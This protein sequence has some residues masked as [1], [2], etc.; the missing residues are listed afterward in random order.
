MMVGFVSFLMPFMIMNKT[1][2]SLLLS[3]FIFGASFGVTSSEALRTRLK[4]PDEKI[5]T[6]VVNKADPAVVSVVVSKDLPILEEYYEDVEAFGGFRIVQKKSRQVGSSLQNIGGGTAFFINK[7]GLLIT[8]EHVVN[9]VSAAYTVVMNDGVVYDA[10]VL[11]RDKNLDLALLKVNGSGFPIIRLSS[12]DIL[13]PG[14]TVIAIGNSLGE[15][16]N[17]VSKGII[18]GLG[19]NVVAA[20]NQIYQEVIQT[21]AAIN[22]GNSGGPLLNT[23]GE[24]VGVNFSIVEGANNVSFAVPVSD[25]KNFVEGYDI[26]LLRKNNPKLRRRSLGK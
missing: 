10:E 26:N 20:D 24:L 1:S 8:N 3:V 18:S 22:T 5:V 2:L 23:L 19:R 11:L 14:Q 7:N 6:R 9:D 15:F 16:R 17:T 4:S 21:D 25:V 13:A 12:S